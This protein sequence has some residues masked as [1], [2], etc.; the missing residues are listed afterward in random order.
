MLWIWLFVDF[1]DKF[2]DC[3]VFDWIEIMIGRVFGNVYNIVKFF[4]FL[5]RDIVWNMIDVY[6]Y[7]LMRDMDEGKYE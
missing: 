3:F 4:N 7:V 5:N 2:L 1:C 6:W